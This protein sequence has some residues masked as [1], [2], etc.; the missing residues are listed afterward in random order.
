MGSYIFKD[1]TVWM[2]GKA[3]LKNNISAQETW[4]NKALKSQYH[5][6]HPVCHKFRPPF[7]NVEVI[8]RVLFSQSAWDDGQC[9]L[10]PWP[11]SHWVSWCYVGAFG[12][13]SSVCAEP[14]PLPCPLEVDWPQKVNHLFA[15]IRMRMRGGVAPAPARQRLSQCVARK[16][17]KRNQRD[18]AAHGF[19]ILIRCD[20]KHLTPKHLH[21]NQNGTLT[22]MKM[23]CHHSISSWFFF[24]PIALIT[25]SLAHDQPSH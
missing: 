3:V 17:V 5:A 18:I 1:L 22:L 25:S 2:W 15:C 11:P 16:W 9:H 10:D 21:R 6:H 23:L 14:H 7:G 19:L 4:I 12:N 20:N 13:C 24:S 8:G